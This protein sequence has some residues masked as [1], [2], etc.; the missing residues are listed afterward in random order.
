MTWVREIDRWFIDRVYVHHAA[1]RRFALHLLRCAEDADE[2]VQEVYARLMALE[3]WG[4]IADPHAFAIRMIR[5]IAIERFR[6]AEVVRIDRAAVLH[7]IDAVDEAPRPDAV[8]FDRAELRRVSR[9]MDALPQRCREALYLRRVDGLP[10]GKVAEKMGIA[11]STVEKHLV[12]GVRLL[13][14]ALR[15]APQVEDQGL[16]ETWNSTQRETS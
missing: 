15:T 10:P 13:H 4:R 8:A 2:V 14:A 3:D 12:K 16:E 1:H 7:E 5:N 11:V 6:R 9:A